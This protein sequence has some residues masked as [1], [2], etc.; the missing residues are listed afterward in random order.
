MI[1]K[2]FHILRT[3][4]ALTTNLKVVVSSNYEL[5]LESIESDRFLNQDKFKRF[6]INK[7][8]LLSI[9]LPK[10]Y[11][12]TP[13]DIAFSVRYDNDNDIMFKTFD[14]Q[15]DSL[16]FTGSRTV[17][18]KRHE[19]EFE[20]FAPLHV[21]PNNMPSNFVIFRVDG[22][23]RIDLT[24]NN[25]KEELVDKFKL[26]SMFDLEST[27]LGRFMDN[28]FKN[29]YFPKSPLELD[30]RDFEF[31]KWNG[32]DYLAGGYSSKSF[33]LTDSFKYELPFYEFEKFITEGYKKNSV[34]YPNIINLTFLFDDTPATP[35]QLRKYSINRYL[36][37]YLDSMDLVETVTPFKTYQLVAGGNIQNN[38][39]FDNVSNESYDPID[40][41]WKA[42]KEYFVWND[43]QFHYLTRTLVGNNQY[44]YKIISDKVFDT[45]T[46]P[47]ETTDLFNLSNT[48]P[49]TVVTT[50]N[51]VDNRTELTLS[52]GTSFINTLTNNILDT[53]DVFIIKIDGKCH[54]LMYDD[55][56]D[57]FF[58][59][60]D[61]RI[62][63]NTDRIKYWINGE[64]SEYTTEKILGNQTKQNKP[65]KF[66]IY[67][68]N[69][70]EIC[71]FD[72]EVKNTDFAGYEYEDLDNTDGIYKSTEVKF[73]PNDHST[74]SEEP[75]LLTDNPA[76]SEYIAAD[77]Y[78]A[79]NK[80][81]NLTE[82]WRK[83][84][85]ICKW[86][87]MG[88]ISHNDYPYKINNQ[89]SNIDE[90]NRAPNPRITE[91]SRS[92]ANLDYFYT[93]GQPAANYT[94][95]SLHLEESILNLA[96]YVASDYDYFSFLFESRTTTNDGVE[97]YIHNNYKY[98]VF[99]S[100]DE[101]E[102]A[103][104]L[105]RGA[106]FKIND[107]SNIL[108]DGN[109]I[110][111]FT[112]IDK[113]RYNNY[114]FSIR[115]A[116][117]RDNSFDNFT[118]FGGSE[119]EIG[120]SGIDVYV[121]HK[122]KNVLV[123]IY[124]NNDDILSDV[125]ANERDSLYTVGNIVEASTLT[126]QSLILSNFIN[127]LNSV[128]VKNGF[129][130]F[131]T[132]WVIDEDGN[133][134]YS[135]V[136]N[137]LTYNSQNLPP[138]YLSV[139]YPDEFEVKL[140]SLESIP[141][142]GPSL[143]TNQPLLYPNG[144]QQLARKFKYDKKEPEIRKASKTGIYNNV[145]RI[146]RFRGQYCPIFKRLELF[147]PFEN[148][149][150]E[151]YGNYIFKTDLADFGIIKEQKMS[152]VNRFNNVLKLKDERNIPSRYPMIDEFGYFLKD[153]FIFKSTWDDSYYTEV[154]NNDAAPSTVL[155]DTKST[156][157]ADEFVY[158]SIFG[159]FN[160]KEKKSFFGSKGMDIEDQILINES[161]VTFFEDPATGEQSSTGGTETLNTDYNF[162][163]L[164]NEYHTIEQKKLQTELEREE[165]TKWVI[166]LDA[167]KLLKD[168][169][170]SSIKNARTFENIENENTL[171]NKVNLAVQSYIDFNLLDRYEIERIDF[172]V[173]YF[174]IE[175]DPSL[176]RYDP[177]Y[178][179][180]VK[181]NKIAN[182]GNAQQ[183][184]D[185]SVTG[186]TENNDI[187]I[188][189]TQT[190]NSLDYKYDYYFDVIFRRT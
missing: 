159:T 96:D 38:I 81:D 166:K 67:R 189:Y 115:F 125:F 109:D 171:P 117:K 128:N 147:K 141:V 50:Y 98:A 89:I 56:N 43:G 71:D 77:E 133:F 1:D 174:L 135:Q 93:L 22:A 140:E 151:P 17:V 33:F 72:H 27:N 9:V 30:F 21:N 69:F 172:Y 46:N 6:L 156:Y 107:V 146:N 78:Y 2:S 47:L 35:E 23:G 177:L 82:L 136:Y 4:T 37:F 5:Y 83:N 182:I 8:D 110:K 190:K 74:G 68:L 155:P 143:K 41:G 70:T 178:S 86:G 104:C 60:T 103:T 105:F 101:T 19:E 129:D 61:Y 64:D 45:N 44:E 88:S 24:A 120:Q 59:N 42:D 49:Y 58:I 163:V 139:E 148:N 167:Q 52:D 79:F 112:L 28:N 106:K 32:I 14:Q 85:T 39:F 131:L 150:N 185:I 183:T 94:N 164:K 102:A 122:Y 124:V 15:I 126:N 34:V 100:G 92:E 18:D 127:I 11:G 179:L 54:T 154:E 36:G 57:V 158:N 153:L 51:D 173:Q 187:E 176:K 118:L 111:Q 76:S 13:E 95:H 10:F 91:L 75:E 170:F 160:M 55:V 87:F 66:E 180:N 152:K 90:Y 121:N 169:L 175:D 157:L 62:E 97:E 132:Y 16:Y 84:P 181:Q 29:K 31:S 63:S 165:I 145:A 119:P 138:F 144:E 142:K 130:N 168:Y 123:H 53:G 186:S 25:F 162:N 161:S 134:D 188:E 20:Y 116:R 99:N 108:K 40:G 184:T 114:K 65:P 7:D 80:D 3:N 113:K 149:P 137:K 26:V 48:Q 73:Y 12:E